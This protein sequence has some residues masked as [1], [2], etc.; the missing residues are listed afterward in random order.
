MPVPL[1]ASSL[2]SRTILLM[3]SLFHVV[4]WHGETIQAWC[5]AGFQNLEEYSHFRELLQ[6]PEEDT[7]H[8]VDDRFP[9][10]IPLQ[11]SRWGSQERLLLSKV[12]P[13]TTHKDEL[14][15][16]QG[17][18]SVINTDDASLKVFMEHLVKIVVEP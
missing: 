17:S 12:N 16:N 14:L 7:Q 1:D 2:D 8:L 15:G 4:I 13:S 9:V 11:T 6:A 3:D 18:G 5:D 10:P